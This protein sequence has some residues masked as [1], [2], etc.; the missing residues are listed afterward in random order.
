M[1]STTN[2][3]NF[4]KRFLFLLLTILLSIKYVSAESKLESA[5]QEF[6]D[7]EKIAGVV[8]V[9]ATKDSVLEFI[10]LG[11]ANIENQISMQKNS[12]FRVASQTKPMTA[13]AIMILAEEGKLSLDDE[14]S[15]YIPEYANLVVVSEEGQTHPPKNK[16]IVRDLL[17]H[18]SGLVGGLPA[19]SDMN[20]LEFMVKEFSKHP[21]KCE[22]S[23][24]HIYSNVGM[25]SAGR[26][27][28][29]ASGMPYSQF[30][31]ERIFIPLE[32]VDTTF[33]PTEEQLERFVTAYKANDDSTGIIAIK[34]N[35]NFA[36]SRRQPLP[37]NGLFST[38]P[39]ILNFC[40]MIANKGVFKGK[41]I[42]S[43]DSVNEM[44]KKQTYDAPTYGLGWGLDKN[45]FGHN[46]SLGT[47]MRIYND[48]KI[49]IILSQYV[50]DCPL[51]KL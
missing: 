38:A 48:S 5:L 37:G 14:V 3:N 32:M 13:L 39:D 27:I 45:Y 20:T 17:S 29:V 41:R 6:I 33:V 22:P 24:K 44:T 18:S 12:L 10:T 43:E 8:A 23:T 25:I 50:G 49:K 11:Y 42:V 7:D 1:K 34:D 31:K 51:F 2:Q 28:E 16:M 21:L 40:Q 15:K 19:L 35:R 9:V 36:D 46:G 4:M 47:Y 26:V 30:M